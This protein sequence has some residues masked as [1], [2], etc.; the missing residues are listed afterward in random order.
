[1]SIL[2]TGALEESILK[3]LF[4]EQE[5]A[6]VSL[7]P[8][9]E[10]CKCIVDTLR[11]VFSILRFACFAERH[12]SNPMWAHYADNHRGV[13]L[14]F[15][16]MRPLPKGPHPRTGVDPTFAGHYA[17]R[18]SNGIAQVG[19]L[20]NIGSALQILHTKHPDWAYEQEVRFISV[21]DPNAP[22]KGV[23][24]S[25]YKSSLTKVI[26][27]CKVPPEVRRG[28]EII[29]NQFSYENTELVITQFEH[30]T[31]SL[32]YLTQTREHPLCYGGT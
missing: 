14:E 5:F 13:C 28:F 30:R 16:F 15:R 25:F 6:K 9:Q 23:R 18:Y 3:L 24:V 2:R 31:R 1:M 22:A 11:E 20:N 17:I 29:L 12:D 4:G 32:T 7:L 10:R 21:G 27:G 19:N 26:L 8:E